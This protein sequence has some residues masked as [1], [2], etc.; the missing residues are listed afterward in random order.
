MHSYSLQRENMSELRAAELFVDWLEHRLI[1][2]GRGDDDTV[3][4]VEPSGKFWLGRL[5]SEL[6]VANLGLGDRGERLEPCATGLRVRPVGEGPWAFSVH[7]ST[8]VWLWQRQSR[9]WQKSEAVRETIEIE[10]P[11]SQPARVFGGDQLSGALSR[12]SGGVNCLSAEI[13]VELEEHADGG[14]EIAIMLVNTSPEE[15]R[16]IRDTRLYECQLQISHLPTRPFTL[17][18]LPDSF[19]YDRRVPAYGI[20]CGVEIRPDGSIATIESIGV[21]KMRPR[22]WG[23]DEREPDFRFEALAADPVTAANDLQTTLA[24]WGRQVWS[25]EALRR[26]ADAGNWSAEMREEAT[27]EAQKFWSEHARIQAGAQLLAE[28]EPLRRAFTLMNLAMRRSTRG[29]YDRWRAF[30]VG[31]LLANLR[32][33]VEP[34]EDSAVVDIVWFATG[35]GKTET[36]LGLVITA[37]IHD[38]LR[39]KITGVTAWSRFPLRMLSLQQ[40]QRFADAIAAAEMIRRENGI[41]GDS[42]SLGFL[43]GSSATPN[44]IRP[45]PEANDPWDPDD[46]HMPARLKVL[47]RCPFCGGDTIDTQFNR[48]DWKLEHRCVNELCDWPETALPFYIVDD[49]LYR[50]LPTV[51]VGTLDKAASIA[52][53]QAMRGLVGPPW[54]ICDQVS[55]GFVYAPRSNKPNGCL[56]PGCRGARSPLPM[57]GHLFGPSFRL[58]DELHLLRDSLGAVDSHYEALYDGLQQE[59]CGA[60]AKILASSATL[61]GYEKQ[62]EVLYRRDARVFPLQGPTPEEGFWTVDSTSLMRR[63]VAIA[64]RGVTIEYTVDRLLTE[65]QRGVRRL[66]SNPVAVC[67]EAGIDRQHAAFLISLY[68]TN[69]VYGNTLRDLDAV[70]RS[71]ETQVLVDGP[72]NVDSLTGRTNFQEVSGILRRLES[73]EPDFGARLHLISASSMMSHGVDIDRLNIMVM[74]GIPLGTA[75]FIQSSARIGRRWPGLVFVVHKIGRERDA[76]VFRSFPK[77]VEQGDRFIEPVPITGRSRRVLERTVAG[78]ELARIWIVHEPRAGTSVA[79]I[80]GLAN[81][82]RTASLDFDRELDTLLGYLEIDPEVDPGLREEVAQWLRVFEQNLQDPRADMRFPNQASPTGRPMLSLRDVE[83]QVPL[84]LNRGR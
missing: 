46:E 81:Y 50:F 65:L 48:L 38:R 58:Q 62:C 11:P 60:R 84:F 27:S 77:F 23:S 57:P 15:D 20:N 22:F 24:N 9:Q 25:E 66:V 59:L 43:V 45:D 39:G 71:M 64:P 1:V 51:V 10:M 74:L 34:E 73:P 53:Q 37:A 31:F 19:R 78:L 36:Y 44:S 79:T 5:V 76:S 42:F 80:R 55:H 67:Q 32:A 41:E 40:M 7:I 17:E 14:S 21:S 28:N 2:A 16:V 75:E 47:Q 61:T 26:R 29:R 49:E 12:I 72:L 35:G 13:R 3:L 56:V 30:Q 70:V 68:G 82:V 69:V 54:G 4:D 63:F 6:Y 8:V 18:A 33:I 52:M 83:E